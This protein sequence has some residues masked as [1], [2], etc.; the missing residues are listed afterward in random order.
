M[1]WRIHSLRQTPALGIYL[2]GGVGTP[3]MYSY[4]TNVVALA[5]RKLVCPRV[6]LPGF[7]AMKRDVYG[8]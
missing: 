6:Q 2:F 3:L 1:S 5:G 8:R 4:L 7:C